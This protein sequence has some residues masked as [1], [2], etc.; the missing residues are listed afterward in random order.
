M[1]SGGGGHHV[2]LLDCVT[3][4]G[5][6]ITLC[7]FTATGDDASSDSLLGMLVNDGS[8]DGAGGTVAA[9][10]GG[11]LCFSSCSQVNHVIDVK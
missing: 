6:V 3:D 9:V 5:D 2:L 1:T 4:S 8:C 11:E 10:T 7:V